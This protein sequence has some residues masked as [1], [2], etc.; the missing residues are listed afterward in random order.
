MYSTALARK[1]LSGRNP[2]RRN[3]NVRQGGIK[4]AS[5]VFI[6]WFSFK[7]FIQ[8]S[9]G[10]YLHSI[11]SEASGATGFTLAQGVVIMAFTYTHIAIP[12]SRR[13]KIELCLNGPIHFGC[14]TVA[15]GS[16]HSVLLQTQ[17]VDFCQRA[18]R[19]R[20]SPFVDLD[21]AR[22]HGA[23]DARLLPLHPPRLQDRFEIQ[24]R[25]ARIA[26]FLPG[27]APDYAHAAGS[28]GPVDHS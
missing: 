13:A 1:K 6:A 3:R 19:F 14:G 10:G 27:A 8:M 18:I 17:V 5:F 2:R 26:R 12:K 21:R 4:M 28:R 25:P 23:R 9:S 22:R 11:T 20:K 15:N 16:T 24:V 7:I